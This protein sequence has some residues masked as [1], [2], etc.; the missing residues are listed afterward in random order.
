[1]S[2]RMYKCFACPCMQLSRLYGEL[3]NALLYFRVPVSQTLSAGK[4]DSAFLV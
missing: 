2:R 1:M 4:W 3:K